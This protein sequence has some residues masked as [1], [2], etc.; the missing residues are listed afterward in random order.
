VRRH[1]N[2]APESGV[3][4]IATVSGDGFWSVCHGSK[5][6]RYHSAYSLKKHDTLYLYLTFTCVVFLLRFGAGELALDCAL[7]SVVAVA[8]SLPRRKK[9]LPHFSRE[10]HSTGP[11]PTR[12]GAF[13][14]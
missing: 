10:Q 3:E 8:T 12:R 5:I 4:F 14:S 2:L 6:R 11:T 1:K 13:Y 7:G 9:I